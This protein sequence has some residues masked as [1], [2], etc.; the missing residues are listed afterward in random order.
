MP[1][2]V[3]AMNF[4][5][6]FFFGLAPI[7]EAIARHWDPP[8]VL[9]GKLAAIA[10]LVGLNGF[11]VACEF[12]I[13]KVRASQLDALVEEGDARADF[14]KH[15]R[16]HLDAYLSA[17]QLGVT[18]ASL[19]LGWIGEQ[20]LAQ[21]LQPFFA[22]VGI[23]SYAVVTS[24]SVALAFV[25]ITF[26]HIVFGELGPKYTAISKPLPTAL[27]LVRLLGAFYVV[28]RP[29][30]WLLHKSSNFLLHTVLRMQPASSTELAHSEEELRLILD[31]SEKSEEVSPMGRELVFNVLDLRDR[32]VR[33]IMT[34]RGEVVYLD[35]EEDFEANV[36]K[37]IESRH[38]RFP[39]CRG[40]LD[41]TVGLVHVKEL[42]PM[43][44]DSRPDLMRIK[45]DLIPVPEMMPLEKLLKL[46]LTRHAHL[47]M[48]V[49]EYGGTVGM[50]TMEN[51]LEEL[52]GDIQDEFD[53]EKEE[54]RKINE[55]EFVVDGALGLYE[56]RDAFGLE[57]D[58]ADVSTIGGYVTHLLGHLP[59]QGEQ[60]K[61]DN[62]LVTVSQSDSRRVHQLHFRKLSESSESA[63]EPAKSGTAR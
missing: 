1:E 52:V 59:K 24:I 57:L 23:H 45:R 22:Y 25:G 33:D 6:L 4:F 30:I 51:V 46:F 47:A 61:I 40:H 26:L 53:A 55:N 19:A 38:T 37:V 18:L 20:F 42:L 62:Y 5:L 21:I 43:M 13:V 27:R 8:L 11:F 49:D 16:S 31:Q 36:N 7:T 50:V 58:S 39:L 29:V 44:R 34:P 3:R 35:V 56:M 14:V 41:N 12:A 15:V 54:F 48:V 32:V 10:A 63:S 2:G 60:V 17:T 28:F 9:I